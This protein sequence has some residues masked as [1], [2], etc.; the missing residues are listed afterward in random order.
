MNFNKIK[1]LSDEKNISLKKLCVEIDVTEQGLQKMFANN[2]M[3]IETLEKIAKVFDVPVSYFFD[4]KK[5]DC[6]IQT[7]GHKNTYKVNSDEISIASDTKE[8]Y[9]DLEIENL[10]QQIADLKRDKEFLQET[11]KL[12]QMANNQP[13]NT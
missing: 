3:K 13:S 7:N 5:T 8:T 9:K 6:I 4:D 11:I 2:S 12:F 10:K 1:F